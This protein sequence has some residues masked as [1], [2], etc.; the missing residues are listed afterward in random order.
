MNTD[1]RKINKI[2]T[3]SLHRTDKQIGL[4][5]RWW[6]RRDATTRRTL[7]LKATFPLHDSRDKLYLYRT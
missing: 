5:P 4:K 1:E 2:N 7:Q 3:I 6:R